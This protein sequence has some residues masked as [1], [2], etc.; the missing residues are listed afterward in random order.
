MVEE[1]KT[2]QCLTTK[3]RAILLI[4]IR[5]GNQS[6]G[7]PRVPEV[8]RALLPRGDLQKARLQSRTVPQVQ[9]LLLETL[10]GPQDLR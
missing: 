5:I 10:R 1:E 4:M 9:Q 3:V 7:P 2:V 6:S 8:P